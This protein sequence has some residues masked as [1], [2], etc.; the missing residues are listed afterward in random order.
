MDSP[1]SDEKP[2]RKYINN[3]NDKL[4]LS[5]GLRSLLLISLNL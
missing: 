1:I 3:V 5:S 2:N 4:C